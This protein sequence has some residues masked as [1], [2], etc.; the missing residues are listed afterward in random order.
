MT[1]KFGLLTFFFSLSAFAKAPQTSAVKATTSPVYTMWCDRYYIPTPSSVYFECTRDRFVSE[2]TTTES[3]YGLIDSVSCCTIA[4]NS[5]T[6][7]RGTQIT[8][9]KTVA[10]K[11]AECPAGQYVSG[12]DFSSDG[13]PD[14]FLCREIF[15]GEKRAVDSQFDFDFT[16]FIEKNIGTCNENQLMKGFADIEGLVG[17]FESMKCHAPLIQE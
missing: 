2:L 12:I 13:R 17:Q 6:A 9:V 16:N 1:I 15:V 11:V 8:T 4:S 3:P 14:A 10:G 7:T 5:R